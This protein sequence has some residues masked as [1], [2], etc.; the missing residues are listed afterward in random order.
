MVSRWWIA[1]TFPMALACTTRLYPGPKRPDAEIA[2]I[3]SDG[4]RIVAVDEQA[5]ESGSRFEVAPGAHAVT[6]LIGHELDETGRGGGYRGT[7]S[8]FASPPGPDT[9]TWR[10][11]CTPVPSGTRR[12]LTKS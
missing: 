7:R 10:D 6:L 3:E 12:S 1:L 4:V 8:P 9:S 5:T 11:R 2:A